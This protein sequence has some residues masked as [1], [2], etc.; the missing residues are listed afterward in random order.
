MS[1]RSALVTGYF[2]KD[3]IYR[4]IKENKDIICDGR[5]YPFKIW[6][7]ERYLEIYNEQEFEI[8]LIDKIKD[9]KIY[10]LNLD[11]QTIELCIEKLVTNDK[12]WEEYS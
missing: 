6:I 12:E 1:G 11:N 3:K 10:D 9:E 8:N 5:K 2:A 7:N 4:Y